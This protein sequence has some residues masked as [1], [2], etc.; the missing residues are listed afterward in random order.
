MP[1]PATSLAPTAIGEW[2]DMQMARGRH[3]S[4]FLIDR[5]PRVLLEG[6]PKNAE[7]RNIERSIGNLREVSPEAY[8]L[9]AYLC[10]SPFTIPVAKLIQETMFGEEAD[11]SHLAE[12]LLSGLV[13]ARSPTAETEDHDAIYYEV[14]PEARAILLG[15]LREAD[16][17][18]IVAELEKR[19]SQHLEKIADRPFSFRGL[20]R[21]ERG[22]NGLP[23]WVQP[24]AQVALSL[25]GDRQDVGD[26][27]P[28][29]PSLTKSPPLLGAAARFAHTSISEGMPDIFVS[30]SR[31]DGAAFA[32]DLRNKLLMNHLSVWPDIVALEGGRDWWS[33]IEET[34]RSKALQHFVL[35]VTPA[36]LASPVVRREIC[37][38]RQEGK[39]VS[40]INGPGL[41][42]LGT[43]PRWLGQV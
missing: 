41:G 30:Y 22:H 40:P 14:R 29:V 36:A 12:L 34:I 23:V 32:A 10:S 37:L 43:L 42:E 4:V 39:T 8:R 24:F 15:A 28:S 27:A 17:E 9:A 2:A 33:Q 1:I 3:G 6:A 26:G 21:D 16:A 7:P 19:V 5:S 25:L 18:L 13:R 11:Q 35:I 38:A 31:K 20:V